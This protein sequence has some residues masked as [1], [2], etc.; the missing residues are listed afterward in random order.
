MSQHYPLTGNCE[1]IEQNIINLLKVVEKKSMK[2]VELIAS[3]TNQNNREIKFPSAFLEALINDLMLT[4]QHAQSRANRQS[5]YRLAYHS[6][7]KG[8]IEQAEVL[9]QFLCTQDMYNPDY[10]MGLAAANFR[11]RNY[12]KAVN[13]YVMCLELEE[14]NY[15][16]MLYAGQCSLRSDKP[17]HACLFFRAIINS[18]APPGVKNYAA[19]LLSGS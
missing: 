8:H 14:E 7:L 3:E 13:L 4:D 18:N 9:Y 2:L 1:Q 17:D 12:G 5:I 15:L 11:N 16:A 6:Y 19:T 10:L